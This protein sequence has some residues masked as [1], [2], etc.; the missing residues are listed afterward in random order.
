[1]QFNAPLLEVQKIAGKGWSA[2]ADS[3]MPFLYLGKFQ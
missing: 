2:L 1:M 3:V